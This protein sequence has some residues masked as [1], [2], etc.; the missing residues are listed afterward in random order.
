MQTYIGT[1]II[2]AMPQSV[3][4]NE[5][6]AVE[7]EGGYKSWSPKDTFENAYRKTT[8]VNYGLAIEAMKMGMKARL[9][10]WSKEVFICIQFPDEHSK[11]TAPYFYVTSRYGLVPWNATQIEQMSDEWEIV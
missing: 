4:N 7:Y 1:K 6:Y 5:G 3:N 10:H 11:M 9:K 2:K 8:G